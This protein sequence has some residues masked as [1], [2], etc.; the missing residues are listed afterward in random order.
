MQVPMHWGSEKDTCAS[1]SLPQF[2][3]EAT[4]DVVTWELLAVNGTVVL[5]RVCHKQEAY[6][7]MEW[8]SCVKTIVSYW[9][10]LSDVQIFYRLTNCELVLD[11]VGN[12]PE[13]INCL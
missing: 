13:E 10:S 9:R 12:S 2:S 11:V 3:Q 5:I 4:R 1:S 8:P 6:S 7:R